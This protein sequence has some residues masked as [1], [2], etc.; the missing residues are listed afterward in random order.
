M[1]HNLYINR[2]RM[3]LTQEQ[4]AR[5]A[6]VSRRT[7][8]ALEST[9]RYPSFEVGARLCRALGRRMEEVFPYDVSV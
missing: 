1:I 5:L 7:V 6:G 4:L 9:G 2:I 3:G 8:N